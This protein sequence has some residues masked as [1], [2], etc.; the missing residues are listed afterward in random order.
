MEYAL[1]VGHWSNRLPGSLLEILGSG[2]QPWG[3]EQPDRSRALRLQ[4]E[5]IA[6]SNCCHDF[7]IFGGS[8]FEGDYPSDGC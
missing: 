8:Y 6:G 3:R 5:T 2:D 7:A 4:Q 1:L